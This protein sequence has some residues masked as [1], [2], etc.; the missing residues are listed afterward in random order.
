MGMS[1]VGNARSPV[2]SL[3]LLNEHQTLEGCGKQK[4]VEYKWFPS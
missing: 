1:E 4:G 2:P 3:L